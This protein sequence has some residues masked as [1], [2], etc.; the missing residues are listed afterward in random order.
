MNIAVI[1]AGGK[2]SRLG[3]QVPKQMLMLG[4]KPVISWSVDT[5]HKVNLIDKI[6]IVSEKNLI[7]EM[8]NFFPPADYPKVSSFIEGGI[9]RSDSSYNALVSSDFNDD[10][11]F[12]FHDAARPFVTEEIIIELINKLKTSG[13]CGTYVKSTDTIAI[14]KDLIVESIPER[15]SVYS[16]QTP[17]GFRYDLI[18]KAHQYRKDV[19]S[20]SVTDDVSLIVN[21]GFDVSVVEGSYS[22]IKITTE[23]DFSFAQFLVSGGNKC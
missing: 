4:S 12:L 7:K 11:I 5:F 15:R 3:S 19:N 23:L 20:T 17:Q 13:A 1:L 22:N 8:K 9:E 21:M 16:A 14:V 18:K 10:D 6:L 2:G